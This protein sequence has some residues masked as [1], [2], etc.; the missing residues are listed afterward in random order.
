M[1]ITPK[2]LNR[3]PEALFEIGKAMGSGGDPQNTFTRIS[4]LVCELTGAETCSIMLL[5]TEGTRLSAN[6]GFGLGRAS[7]MQEFDIGEG[8]AGWVVK[9]G[10][11]AHIADVTLDERFVVRS[12]CP[13]VSSMLC[14]P[15]ATRTEV[16]GTLTATSTKTAAFDPS[17]VDILNFIAMTIAL[18][19][20][21]VRLHRLAVTDSLT[22]VYNREFMQKRLPQALERAAAQQSPIAL[23][24]VDVDHFKA[25]NDEFGHPVGDIVLKEVADRLKEVTRNNDWVIRYGGEE[26]L[27][28]LPRA[29]A[30]RGWE[31]GERIR[32]SLQ[33]RSVEADGAKEVRVSIGVAQYVEGETMEQTIKRADEALYKAKSRGRNRVEVASAV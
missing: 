17:E 27:V 30:G 16:I 32:G 20:Q 24:L 11:A 13:A 12:G 9:N 7:F 22:G 29:D 21:N 18:D 31:V 25:I 3:L 1:S 19:V 2:Q 33:A 14:V 10:T 5:N 26:F 28:V 6:A 23:A 8:V 15:L 4:Q